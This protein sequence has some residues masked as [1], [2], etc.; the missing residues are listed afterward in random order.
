MK[1]CS[2]LISQNPGLDHKE[3]AGIHKAAHQVRGVASVKF[4]RAMF[5]DGFDHDGM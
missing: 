2:V 4:D 1:T 5:G 3:S